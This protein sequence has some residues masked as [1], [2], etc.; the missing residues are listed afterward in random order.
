MNTDQDI[1]LLHDVPR[2]PHSELQEGSRNHNSCFS[3]PEKLVQ[4]GKTYIRKFFKDVKLLWLHSS[5]GN[6]DRLWK[7]HSCIFFQIALENDI[8]TFTNMKHLQESRPK[9][10]V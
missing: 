10:W 3:L 2:V 1:P 7:T 8:I 5:F 9:Y 6:F 4:F